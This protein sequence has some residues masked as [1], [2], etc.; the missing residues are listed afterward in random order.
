MQYELTIAGNHVDPK[1]NP[2]P[3]YR[4]TQ[5]SKWEDPAA[6]R[7]LA[8][9]KYVQQCWLEKFHRYPQFGAGR[10]RLDVTC[11]FTTTKN[12]GNCSHGDPENVRKG[13]QDALFAQDQHVVGSVDYHHVQG[14]DRPRVVIVVS[15]AG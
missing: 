14:N 11:Y 1:G 2:I 6:K 3:Y 9:K 10:Y 4:M 8:W 15:E 13:V 5:A 7:Y 12:G